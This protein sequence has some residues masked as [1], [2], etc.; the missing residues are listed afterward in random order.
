MSNSTQYYDLASLAEVSYVLFDE[1]DYSDSEKV[2]EALQREDRNGH[3]SATQAAD[4]VATW[5]IV[6]HQE[7][8]DSGFSSTLFRNKET[9]ELY[10]AT[11]G[12]E[13]VWPD[14]LETD[15]ADIVTDGLAINQIIDMYNDWQRIKAAE[16]SVY[17][18]AK[19]EIL[20]TE[21]ALLAAE[22]L[23]TP[24]SVGPYEISLR[25]RNDVI[26]DMPLGRVYTLRIDVDS[27]QLFTDDRAYGAGINIGGG[28][29]A[30]GHSLGGHLADAFSRLF[31]EC[32]D[33]LTINGAGY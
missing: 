25:A 32:S 8:T 29:T 3:F 4:F 6:S 16:G 14:L 30:V 18:A 33:V 22:R 23:A 7:N 17:K 21:T 24:W 13:P 5:E 20:S 28:V 9:G 27:D 19:L 31:S 11:R 12:T 15:I 1:F 10:Y 2:K 26:I